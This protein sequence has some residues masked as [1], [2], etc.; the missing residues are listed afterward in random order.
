MLGDFNDSTESTTGCEHCVDGWFYII[1]EVPERI[2][3][4]YSEHELRNVGSSGRA[5]LVQRFGEDS[6]QWRH[7]FKAHQDRKVCR[8][9]CP[10]GQRR[11]KD[12]ASVTALLT[13]LE[14]DELWPNGLPSTESVIG[15]HEMK[16]A[17]VPL[18]CVHWTIDSF[19]KNPYLKKDPD[20]MKYAALAREWLGGGGRAAQGLMRRSDIVIFGPNGT[21]KTGIAIAL[22]HGMLTQ[23]LTGRFVAVRELMLEI[24]DT[25]RSDAESSELRVMRQYIEPHV[26]VLDE[27][28]GLKGSDA[29]V[30][31]LVLLVDRRQKE[32]K[33]TV[34]TMNLG[35]DLGPQQAA[36]EIATFIGP[37][38]FDRLRERASF[39]SMFGKSKRP[40]NRKLVDI[41]DYRTGG[42]RGEDDQ[43]S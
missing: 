18:G 42:A 10:A 13:Q 14:L 38:L 36:K 23:Q 37:T 9:A 2:G 11:T 30:D 41:D 8:C 26:L 34:F 7:V 17:G 39:W 28:S 6:R 22:L 31:T 1:T 15:E 27:L 33:P 25:Y 35:Q 21:G 43:T 5:L 4:P 16:A 29:V 32:N 24:R 19:A 40:T 3:E 12:A 20:A